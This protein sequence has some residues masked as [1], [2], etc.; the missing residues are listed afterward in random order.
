MIWSI[1]LIQS[2]AFFHG[3]WWKESENFTALL[4][5][6]TFAAPEDQNAEMLRL[7]PISQYRKPFFLNILKPF[8]QPCLTPD[9]T[10]GS[11]MEHNY[12]SIFIRDF[13]AAQMLSF[14]PDYQQWLWDNSRAV[15]KT[16]WQLQ[17]RHLSCRKEFLCPP[18]H[19][20]T[21]V[22]TC[23]SPFLSSFSLLT[24]YE[25]K[26]Q[27]QIPCLD[28]LCDTCLLSTRKKKDSISN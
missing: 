28:L 1:S 5:S 20:W 12:Q 13:H 7:N 19:I 17:N 18:N 16:C 21:S 2:E 11:S 27:I 22:K 15:C 10:S 3:W 4:S 8:R 23:Y 14:I 9:F 24:W 25:S 6:L 26:F